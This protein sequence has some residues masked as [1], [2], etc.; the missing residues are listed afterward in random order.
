MIL[1]IIVIIILIYSIYSIYY[2]KYNSIKTEFK[3]K[4]K[5]FHNKIKNII[6]LEKLKILGI[7]QNVFIIKSKSVDTHILNKLELIKINLS[8]YLNNMN[9]KWYLKSEDDVNDFLDKLNLKNQLLD[10]F[11][12]RYNIKNLLNNSLSVW[13]GGKGTTT[14][15]HKDYNDL[16]Y[17]YVVQ[18]IKRVLIAS[19]TNNDMYEKTNENH[20][21][22]QYSE[23][24]F[25]NPDYVKF[26]NYKNVTIN[27]F[28]LKEG[29]SIFIPQNRWH[30][31]ENLEDTLAITYNAFT[32]NYPLIFLP[33]Y[34]YSLFKYFIGYKINNLSFNI[35]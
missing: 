23:V 17:L 13:C 35:N 16:S 5:N 14:G 34:L 10:L 7:N 1:I 11:I 29:D 6:S 19:N 3:I 2:I 4:D 28:I 24:D 20:L 8:K 18:G 27:E 22:C 9:D 30:C 15:W 25:M 33:Q 12:S 26:P 21:Y 31:V 32:I